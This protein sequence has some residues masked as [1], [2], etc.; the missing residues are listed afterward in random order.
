M[1]AL[2]DKN[3]N[4]IN[5][6]RAQEASSEKFVR[7]ILDHANAVMEEAWEVEE[8]ARE[9]IRDR[10]REERQEEKE[11]RKES[12][13]AAEERRRRRRSGCPCKGR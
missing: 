9:V 5:T 12:E 2:K 11:A 3:K 6:I 1:T 7:G 4:L 8:E 13:E 10:A